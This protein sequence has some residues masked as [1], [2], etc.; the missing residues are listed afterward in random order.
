M[1][2][3]RQST[4][5]QSRILGPFVDDTDFRTAETALTIANTDVRLMVNGA[6]SVN[7]N[8]G[9]GTHRINGN[10]S[11]TFDATDTA[12]VGELSVSVVVA[13]ALPVSKTFFVVEE[14]V[15]DALFAASATGVPAAMFTTALTE[16]YRADGATG[17]V[18]Q[19]LYELIAHAGESSISG[20]T[21]TTR[22]VD[23]ATTAATYT[24]N[25]A[26]TPTSITR[27]T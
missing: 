24:L 12:T 11:F 23:G 2:F 25:D 14:A 6:A 7:K 15:F 18:A 19:L 20:T 16:A 21:K 22:R 26:T 5:S 13:G 9:G 4:A 27:A 8:A 10:Y 17:S 1:N 3:L